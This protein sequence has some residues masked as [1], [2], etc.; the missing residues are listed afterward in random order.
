[1]TASG[2][3][4]TFLG[5]RGEIDIRSRAHHRHSAVALEA[6]D[7][8]VMIDCGLD[9]SRAVW[10]LAPR[11]I[12]LTHAHEDHAGGLRRGSPCPVFG[13]SVTLDAIARFGL[14]EQRVVEPRKP[15]ELR[16]LS[17]EAFPVEHS[18]RAP[19]V[20]YRVTSGGRSLF[21]VPDLVAIPDRHDALEGVDVYVGDGAAITRGIIRTRDGVR[22]GHASIREQ[23]DWCAAEGVAR[24]VF[25][26]CGSEIVRA[27][28]RTS[29]ARVRSLGL[30][31]G[32]EAAIAG[33]GRRLELAP[34]SD[35]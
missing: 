13:S 17:F 6:G 18:L 26:H 15:F 5:T 33:D 22:I 32:L 34:L 2:V 29:A 7:G 16:G 21:Y 24:A 9:W 8:I 23:L 35:R 10:K 27:D 3:V 28:G 31:V 12:V 25:T 4:A 1:L 19:A 20:G 30:A 14:A 11:A